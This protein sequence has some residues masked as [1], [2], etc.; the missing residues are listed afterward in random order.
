MCSGVATFAFITATLAADDGI[1][2][3]MVQSVQ[4]QQLLM[5][6]YT[7]SM[8]MAPKKIYIAHV[9]SKESVRKST[10]ALCAW[11]SGS[12][13]VLVMDLLMR[14]QA[15]TRCPGS[16]WKKYLLHRLKK[17]QIQIFFLSIKVL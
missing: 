13:I 7:W 5:V 3:S 12:V 10:R 16:T 2:P 17:E 14:T 4:L 11:D 1:S 6:S 8:E 9:T 15:G